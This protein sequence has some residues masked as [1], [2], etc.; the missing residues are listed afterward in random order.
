MT[1]TY[2][3]TNAIA[4]ITAHAVA[5]GTAVSPPIND[6]ADAL[7][8]PT[9]GR[10]GRVWWGGETDAPGFP[11]ENVLDGRMVG[12]V[13]HITFIWPISSASPADNKA[14]GLQVRTVKDQ[15]RTRIHGD[16][17]LGDTVYDLRIPEM[18]FDIVVWDGALIGHLDAEVHIS[19]SEYPRT[20]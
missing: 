18:S 9:G 10:I 16:S 1:V 19:K 7:P 12:E 17:Q 6:V 13:I 4:A 3:L 5:A 14:I 8:I 2:S 11:G 15:L 20:P